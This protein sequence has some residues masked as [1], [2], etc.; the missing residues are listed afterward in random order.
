MT[1]RGYRSDHRDIMYFLHYGE[2]KTIE[3]TAE[4]VQD[5]VE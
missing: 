1:E 3:P 4:A 5:G 2:N